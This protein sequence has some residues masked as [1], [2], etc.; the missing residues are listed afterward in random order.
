MKNYNNPILLPYSYHHK[1]CWPLSPTPTASRRRMVRL[2]GR[3]MSTTQLPLRHL[4]EVCIRMTSLSDWLNMLQRGRS[5]AETTTTQRYV[6]GMFHCTSIKK[7]WEDVHA[8][9]TYVRDL[10]KTIH[11]TCKACMSF[12]TCLMNIGVPY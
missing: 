10:H 12:V 5:I 1:L 9:G 8:N 6:I 7:L 3:N 11:F 4:K 2:K